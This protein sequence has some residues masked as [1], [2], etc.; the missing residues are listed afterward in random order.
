MI[1]LTNWDPTQDQD[2]EATIVE[3]V[4]MEEMRTKP[5]HIGLQFVQIG[6]AEGATKFFK[7]LH[8]RLK[9]YNLDRHMVD[10]VLW[11]DG[12]KGKLMPVEKILLGMISVNGG[13][14]IAGGELD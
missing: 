7:R 13:I 11:V 1:I 14:W 12:E 3:Y 6:G 4:R 2:M 10:T 9:Y 8:I 5:F